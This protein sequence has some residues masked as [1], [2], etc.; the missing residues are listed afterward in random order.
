MNPEQK[1][2]ETEKNSPRNL[3]T[4]QEETIQAMAKVE[5]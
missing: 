4:H 5:G 2:I 3:L 1:I